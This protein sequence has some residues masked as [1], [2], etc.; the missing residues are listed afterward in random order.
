MAALL[1]LVPASFISEMNNSLK[2]NVK[3]G[4]A[5]MMSCDKEAITWHLMLALWAIFL[6]SVHER[7]NLTVPRLVSVVLSSAKTID[8][9]AGRAKGRCRRSVESPIV[10][11]SRLLF[12]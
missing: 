8:W 1:T 11:S 9:K 2:C 10:R 12:M 7:V 3:S 6:L 4:Q 5:N